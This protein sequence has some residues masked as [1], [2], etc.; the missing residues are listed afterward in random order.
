MR[1]NRTFLA[2]GIK[3]RLNGIGGDVIRE[4]LAHQKPN[5]FFEP[6]RLRDTPLG[7]QGR[8][9]RQIV[10]D[11]K[12]FLGIT[13][14]VIEHNMTTLEFSLYLALSPTA[15]LAFLDKVR[16]KAVLV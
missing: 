13:G 16:A 8:C 4:T 1:L 9:T 7:E 11:G 6:S 3:A 5:Q 14:D 10:F 2:F 12:K 15:P